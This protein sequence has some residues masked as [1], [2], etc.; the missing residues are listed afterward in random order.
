MQA[1]STKF[2]RDIARM[3]EDPRYPNATVVLDGKELP[4][5]RPL[6]CK[7][8]EYFEKAFKEAFVEGSSG[9]LIFNNDSG[10]AHWRV[11]KYLYASK[12]SDD[13]SHC[14]EASYIRPMSLL[15]DLKALAAVLLQQK[16]QDLCTSK[17]FPECIREVYVTTLENDCAMRSAVIEVATEHEDLF[18]DLIREGGDFPVDYF[19]SVVF[20]Q[21]PADSSTHSQPSGLF[22]S[23]LSG[24]NRTYPTWR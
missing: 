18:K 21:R 8:S 3:F 7:Q 12:Y 1:R 11:L 2:M 5:H 16:L 24:T 22:G 20:P 19:T 15:E 14:F 23:T 10:A 6:V 17:S 4:V 9:V 13:L